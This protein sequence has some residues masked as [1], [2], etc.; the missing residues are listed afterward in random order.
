MKK[1]H[2]KIN[3]KAH[4]HTGILDK[5]SDNF[6]YFRDY[7][8]EKEILSEEALARLDQIIDKKN[9]YENLKY[10]DAYYLTLDPDIQEKL[11]E[12]ARRIADFKQTIEIIYAQKS[13]SGLGD[14]RG[15]LLLVL[16]GVII[17]ILLF[18]VCYMLIKYRK[19]ETKQGKGGKARKGRRTKR[20]KKV[21]HVRFDL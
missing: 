7:S 20:G 17:I 10:L 8:A 12:L 2:K 21:K 11:S 4:L 5:L 18:V 14:N 19:L 16:L 1:T 6:K 3:K 13:G 15:K 9:I